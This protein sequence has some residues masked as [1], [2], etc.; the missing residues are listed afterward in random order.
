MD[1]PDPPVAVQPERF[2]RRLEIVVAKSGMERE[3]LLQW[4]LA[5]TGLS[6][7][8]MIGDGDHPA[9]DLAVAELALAEIER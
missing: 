6:A 5:Y 8:W 7:A 2:H 4:I 3:R 1:F 9:V